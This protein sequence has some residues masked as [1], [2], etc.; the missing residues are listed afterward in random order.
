MTQTH[1]KPELKGDRQTAFVGRA[2]TKKMRDARLR[3]GISQAQMADM[4][5][6]TQSTYSRIESGLI[7]QPDEE[8]LQPVADILG[9]PIDELFVKEDLE[10]SAPIMQ[11]ETALN[12][13][14][15]PAMLRDL[16]GLLDDGVITETQF[17]EKR[18]ELL[19]RL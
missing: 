10:P 5:G 16:K 12:P 1:I 17:I 2:K 11:T 4:V 9:I 8:I 13:K 6:T 7:Q 14:E 3:K 18:K 15:I 19:A